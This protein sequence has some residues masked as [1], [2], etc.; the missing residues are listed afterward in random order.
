MKERVLIWLEDTAVIANLDTPAA[1]VKRVRFYK[2]LVLIFINVI[3]S[4]LLMLVNFCDLRY[5][6]FI[7]IN[8]FQHQLYLY[9]I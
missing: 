5:H 1:V 4:L 2:N 9:T 3:Q 6:Y 7:N 8:N